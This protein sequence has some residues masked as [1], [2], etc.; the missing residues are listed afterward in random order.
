MDGHNRCTEDVYPVLI[1]DASVEAIKCAAIVREITDANQA[2]VAKLKFLPSGEYLE[3]LY[4]KF[5]I[6]LAQVEGIAHIRGDK[7]EGQ[8]E[9]MGVVELDVSREE[10]GGPYLKA[11][12]HTRQLV[13]LRISR[14]VIDR[15]LCLGSRAKLHIKSYPGRDFR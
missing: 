2:L 13:Y 3:R 7:L 1:P 15:R 9:R 6:S 10:G 11:S 14:R 12:P 4:M 8:T 5:K